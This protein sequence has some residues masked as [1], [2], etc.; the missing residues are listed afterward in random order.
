MPSN[1]SVLVAIFLATAL[2]VVPDTSDA[3]SFRVAQ[4]PNGSTYS[5]DTC[6]EVGNTGYV[7]PFGVGVLSALAQGGDVKWA[8]LYDKDADGDGYTNGFELGDPDGTWR[9]G[10]PAPGGKVSH[11]GIKEDSPCDDGTLDPGETPEEGARR[12]VKEETGRADLVVDGYLGS[13][14]WNYQWRHVTGR[15]RRHF[16][17]GRFESDAPATWHHW[18]MSPSDGGPPF[19]M[20]FYW[21]PFTTGF[22]RLDHGYGLKLV[23]LRERLAAK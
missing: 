16:Y 12:E 10:D 14:V 21:V 22:P 7:N 23:Q 9:I 11:P 15:Y 18:E 17:F 8:E 2:V 3:K 1:Q 13:H 4:L 19:P 6:H 5:C 20:R